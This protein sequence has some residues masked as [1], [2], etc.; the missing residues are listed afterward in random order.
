MNQRR[1][2][3]PPPI[4]ISRRRR[5]CEPLG[6]PPPPTRNMRRAAADKVAFRRRALVR[7]AAP[8]DHIYQA[9][10]TSLVSFF[11]EFALSVISVISVISVVGL[12]D[13]PLVLWCSHD[14]YHHHHRV[15]TTKQNKTVGR[16]RVVPGVVSGVLRYVRGMSDACSPD[17]I[18]RTQL[19]TGRAPSCE[20]HISDHRL[21]NN[22]N[23]NNN[24]ERL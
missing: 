9:S 4:L 24:N 17:A 15:N 10:Q 19:R 1:R 14:G 18:S 6:A 21:N 12:G 23:N 22:N 3:P 2:T 13:G 5:R 8:R 16:S 7:G 20:H 11:D